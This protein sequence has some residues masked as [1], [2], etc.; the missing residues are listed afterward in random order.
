VSSEKIALYYVEVSNVDHSSKGGGLASENED[1][2][3]EEWSPSD[4]WDALENGVLNDAK[5][6]IAVQWLQKKMVQK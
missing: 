4:L 2:K 3:I 5:T 6:I 1:I